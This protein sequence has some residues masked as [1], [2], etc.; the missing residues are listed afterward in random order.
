MASLPQ[1]LSASTSKTEP[2][3]R[4][5]M[6][7]V[8]PAKD[9][10]HTTLGSLRKDLVAHFGLA[11][12]A[13]DHQKD[14]IDEIAKSIMEQSAAPQAEAE[15]A[16]EEV[17]DAVKAVYLVTLAHP[18]ESNAQDG[19]LLRAPGSYTKP[20][21]LEA[22]L[23]SIKYLHAN[24]LLAQIHFPRHF[25]SAKAAASKGRA[26]ATPQPDAQALLS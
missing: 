9:L 19:T 8:L 6:Q 24:P 20:E 23:E 17:V 11:E 25:P 2:E 18:K 13:L 16:D 14:L 12:G 21:I 1:V 15:D 5:A 22:I 7:S 3:L 4:T 10:S 26:F